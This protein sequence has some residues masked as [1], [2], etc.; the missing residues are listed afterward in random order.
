MASLEIPCPECGRLLRLPDRKMLGRKARCGKCN[1]RF[2]LREPGLPDAGEPD[3]R[4]DGRPT[5]L[6]IEFAAVDDE[7]VDA[8]PAPM[9]VAAQVAAQNLLASSPSQAADWPATMPADRA[10]F[11]PDAVAVPSLEADADVVARARTR[12]SAAQRRRNVTLGISVAVAAV[13]G[14]GLYLGLAGGHTDKSNEKL[15][16]AAAKVEEEYEESASVVEDEE[17]GSKA[18]EPIVLSPVPEGARIVIHLRPAELWQIGG[19][20]EEFRACLGPLGVWL[21][22]VIKSR[23][24]LEPAK[25]EEVLFALIPISRDEFDFACVVRTTDNVK[26]SELIEKFDGA[27]IDQ[28][29]PHY[30]G[31]DRAWMILDSRTFASA[32][33]SMVESFVQS[34]GGTSITS[35]G[36]QSLLP[37]TDRK[38]H[39]TL[40]CELEDVR[41]GMKNLAPENAQK[42]LEGVLDFLG[43]DVETIAWSLHLGD[44]ESLRNLTCSLLVRNRLSRS[45]PKLEADLKKKLAA[46]PAEILEIAR[47][48]DPKKIGE[49]KIVGRYP[50]MLKVVQ[51]LTH[52]NNS[53]R[54]VTMEVELPERAGP[55]LAV[56]TLFAWNQTTLPGYGKTSAAPAR[57]LAGGEKL[58]DKIAD[59]LKKKITVEFRRTPL[60]GAVAAVSEETGINIKLDGPGMKEVGVTQ[61]MP[62]TFAMDN[63]PATSVLHKIL[64]EG[65]TNTVYPNGALV[66][67]VDEEKKTA[68]VTG[69]TPAEIKKLNPFPLQPAGK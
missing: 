28:P 55:N 61:N 33:K 63:V 50:A 43:D 41:L 40:L 44:A 26:R 31:P 16:A 64:I 13:L 52:F 10:P 9:E 3:A 66:L 68:T 29:R 62:Q 32:P 60:E 48:T 6:E 14:V 27:L 19:S 45:P 39:F 36:I 47:Q 18:P 57:P 34:A 1:H 7:G 2:I 21:E 15:R 30:V 12:K 24:L 17:P 67:I 58:L 23:C 56:G 53:R 51:E 20:A 37:K 54:L 11:A 5:G 46:L 25:I 8:E 38:R 69:I 4:P 42:L 65:T 49:K 35:D 59:R 22:N